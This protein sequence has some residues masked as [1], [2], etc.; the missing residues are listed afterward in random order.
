[1]SLALFDI[2]TGRLR[3]GHSVRDLSPGE[4]TL[5]SIRG[6]LE[7]VL[8]AR[9]QPLP[10][11]AT[12]LPDLGEIYQGLPY[13]FSRLV[14]SVQETVAAGEP[15]LSHVCVRSC[16]DGAVGPRLA[17][18]VAGRCGGEILRFRA[19]FQGGKPVEVTVLSG[20]E[21]HA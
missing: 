4:G 13:T 5:L 18:E 14:A 1:M 16:Q 20:G 21:S 11:L 15:R 2:L 3:D 8:N 10:H 12:G 9:R 19:L 6:N 17:L 7:A